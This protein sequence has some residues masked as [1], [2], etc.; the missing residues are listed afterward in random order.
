MQILQFEA[1][2]C[3]IE[4]ENLIN[5]IELRFSHSLLPVRKNAQTSYQSKIQNGLL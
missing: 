3:R 1:S 2:R 5:L 4:L